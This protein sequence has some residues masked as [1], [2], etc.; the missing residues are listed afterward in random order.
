MPLL[1]GYILPNT[2]QVAAGC[3]CCKH[4]LLT[5]VQHSQLGVHQDPHVLFRQATFQLVVPQCVILH[6]VIPL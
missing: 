2:A 6:G 4:T 3:L 1:A 5:H